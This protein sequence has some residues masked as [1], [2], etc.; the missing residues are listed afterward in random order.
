MAVLIIIIIDLNPDD[1]EPFPEFGARGKAHHDV[2]IRV[3]GGGRHRRRRLL[4]S[5]PIDIVAHSWTLNSSVFYH[6]FDALRAH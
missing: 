3:D 4:L 6:H 5:M 1:P 2:C